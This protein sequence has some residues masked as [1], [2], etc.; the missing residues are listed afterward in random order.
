MSGREPHPA[1]EFDLLYQRF[2]LP[3]YRLVRGMVREPEAAERLT[4]QAFERAYRR[5]AA[6]PPHLSPAAWLHG[7]AVELA[8]A[9]LRPAPIA[10]LLPGRSPRSK[11]RRER[12]PDDPVELALAALSPVLRALVLLHLYAELPAG[13]IAAIL[14]IPGSSVAARLRAATDVMSAAL[15]LSA[16]TEAA[17]PR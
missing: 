12:T 10:R 7:F 8:L 11:R 4:R 16:A 6:Y 5:R 1:T 2:R 15:D 3:V 13:E 9:H 17:E 14:G